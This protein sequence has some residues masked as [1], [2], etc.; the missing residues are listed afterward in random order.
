M[1]AKKPKGKS[2]AKIVAPKPDKPPPHPEALRAR[3]WREHVLKW[4]PER[5][6]EHTGY[7]VHSIYWYERGMRPS[8]HPIGQDAWLRYKMACAGVLFNLD[9]PEDPF[10]WN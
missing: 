6:A 3:Y 5:L 2:K 4:T 7:G 9:L 8:G 1:P 10:E